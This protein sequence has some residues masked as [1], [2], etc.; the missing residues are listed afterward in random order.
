MKNFDIS[1]FDCT[2]TGKNRMDAKFLSLI[3]ELR[4]A[5]Q[6]PFTI[7]SGFRDL[8]HPNE[9]SKSV[10]GTHSQGIAADIAVTGGVQRLRIVQEALRLGFRGIGVAKGFVHVD[11]RQTVPVLWCY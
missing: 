5:C 9:R 1:E 2:H 6:F 8:T 10:G 7:T 3:D 4:T 11:T